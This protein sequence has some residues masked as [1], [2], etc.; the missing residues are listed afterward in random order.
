M[1]HRTF[2]RLAFWGAVAG[3]SVSANFGLELVADKSPQVGLARFTAYT[4]KGHDMAANATATQAPQ[5]LTFQG[6]VVPGSS[7]NP[8]AFFAGT[9]REYVLQK[10]LGTWMGFG[11]TD[12]VD[13]LRSGI[14]SAY[15]IKISGTL[16]VTVGTGT[17]ATTA[18]WPYYMLRAARFQANGQSNLV[19][20]DG[21][22]LRPENSWP[23]PP[24]TTGASPR[25][26]GAPGSPARR[27]PRARSRWRR[28][29]G[30][31]RRTRPPSRR[32][33][34]TSRFLCGSQFVTSQKL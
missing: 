21:W 29:P 10:T 11:N 9:R 28:N 3:V 24:S 26:S 12:V 4:H 20:A 14:L 33:R 2:R 19:N 22:A 30:A 18:R 25:A 27:A 32:A 34:T 17:V 6:I 13:T 23:T 1:R 15:Y 7:L 8:K 5:S 16:V 31:S